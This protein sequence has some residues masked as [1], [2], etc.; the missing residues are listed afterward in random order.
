MTSSLRSRVAGRG[1][2][3]RRGR[4]GRFP[5]LGAALMVP[6]AAIAACGGGDGDGGAPESQGG[7]GRGTI[8]VWAH[9]GQT[10][11]ARVL[12]SAVRSFND[13]Q[14]DVRVSLRL[15]PD[16]EY[17]RTVTATD[18]ADLPD[19]LEFDGPTMA[20]FVYSEKLTPITPYVSSGTVSNATGGIRAQ[21]TYRGQ[22]YGL[23]MYDSALGLYGNK[24]LLDT[25]GVDYPKSLNEVW[26]AD[27]FAAALRALA[28]RDSDGKVL[29]L[30]ESAGFGTE[31][32]TYG[33]SPI[34]WS[35]GGKLI[36]GNKATGVLNTPAV[37]SAFDKFQSWK[38]YV[39]PN[40]D[41]NAMTSR[42]VALSW[43][44]HWLYPDY[45][46]ALGSDLVIMPLPDFGLGPKTGQGSWAW[47]IGAGT[48]EGRAA[49]RF[50]NHLL[51][52][53]TVKAMTDANG[54]PPGTRTVLAQSPLY[55][56]GG[57]LH[58]FAQ[59]LA[60]PCGDTDITR[61]CVAVTRPVT[62]GYPVI[63]SEFSGALNSIYGGAGAESALTTAAR[64]IDRDY[65]DN[66]DYQ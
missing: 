43:V 18:A 44:G 32:G 22:L 27:E 58:L 26:T 59:Q 4:L 57:P 37:A 40:T 15:I 12:R 5:R 64:A 47:G 49:G 66:N 21:G 63:T 2:V 33:F 3:N 16:N 39:D 14:S 55:R 30:Q 62:P 9:Q 28:V 35:A 23:G 56:P 53:A 7:D 20:N 50:L 25:A 61:S 31:W 46:R 10:S 54:A 51:G 24:N 42:R 60:R 13:S 52:D 29:D 19:V 17:T 34:V 48:T 1:Q 65:A 36:E 45:S 11:E 6:V 38:P 41:G 8:T